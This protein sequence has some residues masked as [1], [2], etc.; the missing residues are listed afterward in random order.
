MV[1]RSQP[2]L[3]VEAGAIMLFARALGD[4]NPIYR[5]PA[6][7]AASEPG[8]VIAP[9]TF[10]QSAA[11]F[12]P[13]NRLRPHPGEPWMG[14]SS[15]PT[16][17]PR[18]AEGATTSTRLHAEQHYTYHRPLR[19]G[20][21]LSWRATDGETWQKT[22]RRGAVLTFTERITEYRDADGELVVTAR[23]VVVEVPA[24]QAVTS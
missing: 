18:S 3:P 23:A 14:S 9:P 12:D 21:V 17:T 24:P 15:V 13:G 6:Y 20:D 8:A 5:D 10:V 19:A 4:D 1:D 11:H 22:N 2:S 7:A 16:G